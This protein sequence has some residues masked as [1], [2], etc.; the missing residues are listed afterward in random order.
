MGSDGVPTGL[1]QELEIIHTHVVCNALT[2]RV[3]GMGRERIQPWSDMVLR[4]VHVA[5]L[6]PDSA[7]TTPWVVGFRS[8]R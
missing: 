2:R 8:G 3:K 7:S 1:L 4:V 6:A 5:E